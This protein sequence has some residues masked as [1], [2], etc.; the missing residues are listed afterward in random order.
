MTEWLA[1]GYVAGEW[2][3]RALMV[4][5]VPRKRSP[6][7]ALSWLAVIFFLPWIGIALYA[8]IGDVRLGGVRLARHE[9]ARRAVD[10]RVEEGRREPGAL[11]RIAPAQHDIVRLAERL[12][13]LGPIDGAAGEMLGDTDDMIERL[14]ADIDAATDHVH[15]L[16]YIFI[17]DS[18]G[19][20][21][22][23]ALERAAARGVR[24]RVLADHAGS[25]P[26]FRR[27]ARALR[28]AGVAVAAALPV[29]P[30]RR[31]LARIDVRNHRKIGVIDGRI[32]YTGSHNIVDADYGKKKY[33]PWRD[34]TVRLEGPAVAS[35]QRVFIEDWCSD[36][37]ELLEA[38]EHFPDLEPCGEVV[39][40]AVPS[41]P[42]IVS[43]SFRDLA[44][45]IIAEAEERVVIT[46]PYLIP[47][48]QLML[49]LRIAVLRGVETHVVIPERPDH[50]LVAA[51]G[52][53][54]LTDLLD[55][56]VRVHLHQDGLLHAKTLSVDRSLAVVGTA[57][58]DIRSFAINFELSLIG[59]GPRVTDTLRSEQDRYIARSRDL[60]AA[61]WRSRPEWKR[62]LENIARLLSPLL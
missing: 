30:L 31:F 42:A 23:A 24:C 8:L 7:A 33:G 28:R 34:L 14:C 39:A 27:R 18:T 25:R 26:L 62:V 1:I 45:A 43:G 51:A 58:F 40:Q 29:N 20:R 3:I 38:P 57:N 32:G 6:A 47:D 9:R 36:T 49:S 55:A 2:V 56:G 50:R 53:S 22:C 5:V 37:G 44:V 16:F 61:Q 15:L 52:R 19:E 17:P 11:D 35:L 54:F 12:G 41:G 48:E 10:R 46:S 4:V 21:V 13:G 60:D 59:Y